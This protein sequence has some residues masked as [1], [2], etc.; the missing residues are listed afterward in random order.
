MIPTICPKFLIPKRKKPTALLGRLAV[1]R[2]FFYCR[3]VSV[4]PEGGR[5]TDSACALA[6]ARRSL[7]SYRAGAEPGRRNGRRAI[8][9]M[10]STCCR[11]ATM[12]GCLLS[13]TRST[14]NA[15]PRWSIYTLP[16]TKAIAANPTAKRANTA[17]SSHAKYVCS[18]KSATRNTHIH[19]RLLSL[20]FIFSL[21]PITTPTNL[22]AEFFIFRDFHCLDALP[23]RK[24]PVESPVPVPFDTIL[25][26]KPM[27][28]KT[29]FRA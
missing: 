24:G 12:I 17:N 28:R 4:S 6:R 25:L 1:F 13:A 27:V 22:P 14:A 29:H 8:S 15:Q 5:A 18:E 16:I 3:R 10:A 26:Q 9:S 19:F 20:V 7:K 23:I 2:S 21:V 11:V